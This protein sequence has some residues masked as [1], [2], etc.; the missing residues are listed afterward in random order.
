M[1]YDLSSKRFSCKSCGLY[2]TREEISDI[3]DRA[4]SAGDEDRKKKREQGDYLSWWLSKK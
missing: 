3:R 1:M 2:V 4:R